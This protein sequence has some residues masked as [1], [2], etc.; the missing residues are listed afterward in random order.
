MYLL[1]NEEKP[2][3]R[4]VMSTTPTF[5]NFV[6]AKQRQMSKKAMGKAA[7]R[8]YEL[9]QMIEFDV[10]EYDIFDMPPVTEYTIYMRSFGSSNTRQVSMN[11]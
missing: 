11:I 4:Q 2:R 9:Q 3:K 6:S 1:Q 5:I 7:Q 8:G 10:T